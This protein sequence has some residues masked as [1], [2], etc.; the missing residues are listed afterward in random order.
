MR[1]HLCSLYDTIHLWL[2]PLPRIHNKTL[3]N[4]EANEEISYSGKLSK[5]TPETLENKVFGHPF[6]FQYCKSSQY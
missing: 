4:H 6:R 5:N 3:K 1:V 2:P